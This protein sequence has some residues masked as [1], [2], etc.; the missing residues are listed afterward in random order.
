[1]TSACS[2]TISQPVTPLALV[3]PA[4][5]TG[6]VGVSYSS[7]LV[8]SGGTGNYSY[9][10]AA[11]SFL[12]SGLTLNA[13]TG[14]IA[15]TP[16]VSGSVTFTGRVTDTGDSALSP[17]SANCGI[18]IIGAPT[19]SCVSIA[20][21]Q[22]RAI[23]P[24]TLSGASGAGPPY[25]FSA[26]GLPTGLSIANDGTISGTPAVSG[27]FSYTVTVTDKNGRTGTIICS[28]TVAP[29]PAPLTLA[30][31]SST[32]QIGVAYNSYLVAGGGSGSYTFSIQ[33][34]TLPTGLTLNPS[35]GLISGTPTG[36]T[37]FSFTA[38]VVDSNDSV[39]TPATSGCGISLNGVPT[40]GC[41]SITATQG[42]PITP[43][44]L[45]GAAGAGGPYT[46]TAVGLPAGLTM[47]TSGTISGTPTVSGAFSYTVT[48]KDINGN[49]GTINCSVTVAPPL[50]PLAVACA[51]STGQV[52]VGYNSA[53]VASGGTRNYSY[54]IIGSLP[55]GLA[56]N[57]T[58]GFITG[59]PTT[60][61]TFSFTARVTD[62]GSSAIAPATTNC[63]IT[64]AA[65]PSTTCAVISATQGVAITPATLG[66]L[67]R[68]GAPYSFT[69]TGLPS[70][71]TIST[72]GTISG[73]PTVSGTFSYVIRVADKNGNAGT[74][75]CSITIA[76]PV[77][78]TGSPVGTG[79]TATIGFWNNKN[80]QYLISIANGGGNSTAMA[81]WLATQLPYL[82]GASAGTSN[83]TGKK[84][85]DVAALFIAYFKGG[86]TK[87]NAQIMAAAIAVFITS[88]NLSGTDANMVAQRAKFRF[89][90]STGGTG[91]KTWNVG[92]Y[93]TAIGL[94]NN[95]S[96]TVL[97]LLAQASLRKQLGTFDSN[98]FNVIF[99]GINVK[100]DII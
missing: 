48:V 52:D 80:G 10:L 25:T 12:P 66:G 5:L 8:A 32:G 91:V 98:A 18:S 94:V 85:S 90:S 67:Y 39:L 16:L 51:G 36:G 47:S 41:V 74:V 88:T 43:V 6:Q 84:N 96:Y 95:Q 69:A 14:F 97:Q 11:G 1:V 27:T 55:S 75:T 65:V 24:V 31:A 9:S 100:G 21:V 34:G 89:N 45:I 71:L 20:A 77:F 99:D 83:L 49:T 50:A 28:I 19:T 7:A 3:C 37:A 42:L 26:I 62:T 2:I 56:L 70:G 64:V 4:N 44:T 81:N 72:G 29:A 40:A 87:T 57:A 54:S 15:G 23:T 63:G 59:T 46:F 33:S 82:C 76:P 73:T 58:S 78:I 60:A 53:L 61:G 93:G 30:C 22:G 86:A 68:S 35:T 17:V 38:K 13:S 79:D 92:S